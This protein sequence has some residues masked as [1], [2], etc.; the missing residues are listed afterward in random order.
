MQ[1]ARQVL[2]AMAALGLGGCVALNRGSI[3][4][5]ARP[6]AERTFDLDAFV[7][8][9]NRN[10]ESIQSLEAKATIG[11]RSKMRRG[12]GDGRLAMVRPRNFKLEIS[13][14]MSKS[15]AN[16]GSNDEEFWFSV[17]SSDDPSIYWCKYS[18]LESSAL[19]VAFQPDWIIQSI[20]LKPITPEEADGIRVE[21]TDDPNASALLFP[22]T[23]SRGETYQR[24]MIV[25]NYTRRIKEHRIYEGPRRQTL[26]AKAVVPS[27]KE[28]DLEKSE[29]GAFQSCYLPQSVKL[30]WIKDQ[31]SLDVVLLPEDVKVNQFD[32]SRA[33]ALFVEPDIPQ[34]KRVNLADMARSSPRD[35]RTTARRTLPAP[36]S[37]NGVKLGRPAPVTDE[38]ADA[39]HAR[40]SDTRRAGGRIS[41]PLEELVTAPLPIGAEGDST[42]QAAAALANAET[43]PIGR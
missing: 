9:H 24:M 21:R 3:A 15:L 7:A 16:I 20:G 1:A 41:S 32:A 31:L 8:E 25:S 29:S 6:V 18:E 14:P 5:R 13:G 23:K 11:L 34:Y 38:S 39:P 27:Y 4:P 40:A 37:R 17:Q 2:L 12:Q 43:S 19:S 42:R 36:P 28:Y 26:L 33:A 10:A 30:D 22:P 35:N